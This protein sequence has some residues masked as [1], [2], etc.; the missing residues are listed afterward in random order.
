MPCAAAIYARVSTRDKGQEVENQL[1]QLREFC[2]RQGWQIVH[3]YVDQA[4]AKD[5]DRPEFRT[6]MEAASRQQFDVV[7]FWSLDRLSREGVL[8]TLIHLQ[9]L[10]SCGV[11]WKS[12][13]EQYLDSCGIF[14]DAVLSILATLAK[15]ERIRMSERTKAGLDRARAEGK[16]LGRRARIFRH[17]QAVSLRVQGRTWRE[18]EGI[19]GVPRSTI[20]RALTVPKTAA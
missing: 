3:E 18:I 9:R 1:V 6:M 10:N 2:Q 14:K 5:A 7:L 15:Q 17:E 12:L 11:A 13:T 16:Q 8:A 19:L 20:R 4:S